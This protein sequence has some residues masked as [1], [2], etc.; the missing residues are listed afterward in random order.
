[1]HAG[2]ITV[3]WRT[4]EQVELC[5]FGPIEAR[6][7]L[8][9]IEFSRAKERAILAALA[10]FHGRTLSADRLVDAVWGDRLPARAEKAL[11]THVHRLR[12]VLGAVVVETRSNGYALA[13]NVVVDAEL[14]EDEAR[15]TGSA[16]RLRDALARWRGEPYGDLAAWP[17]AEME[18]ERLYELRDE[19]LE[20]CLELEI[21]AGPTGQCIA[22][23]EAMVADKPLREKRWLL[24]MTAL[25]RDGRV[26]DALRAYQRARKVFAE[27]LGIDPGRELRMLEER[28]LL[29]DVEPSASAD[30]SFDRVDRLDRAVPVGALPTGTV[31]FLITD[32]VGSTRLWEE[33]ADET[34][35]VALDRHDSVLRRAIERHGGS[36]VAWMGDGIAAVFASAGDA[37]DAALEAQQQ[38]M[39]DDRLR[40]RMALHT[41]EGRL[42]SP[43]EYVNRPINRCARLV[44]CAHGGQ[45]L[46]SDSTAAVAPSG[47][48]L[49]S[50]FRDLGAHRLR[51]LAEPM[52]VFQVEHAALPSEFPPLRS[53][54]AVPG[55]LPRQLTSFVGREREIADLARLARE[56]PL[57][58]LTGV[59]GV[60]KTR[61]A[62]QLAAQAI[63]D[64]RD[65]AWLCELAPVTDAN[66]L[67]ESLASSLGVRPQAGRSLLDLVLEFLALKRLVIVLDNCE[68]LLAPAARVV[69]A[70][71]QSCPEVAVVATSREAL[72]VQ[73]EL[74]VAIRPLSVPAIDAEADEL[75]QSDGTRLFCDRARD[76]NGAFMLT[77]GNA[78]A[79]AQLCRQLDG[80]P[81][82]IELAAARVRSLS[83]QDLAA[84]MDQ[85]FRLLTQSSRSAPT[86]HHTLRDTIDWSYD[87][88]N[89][90]EQ[91][92]LN[93]TSVFAGSFD[94]ASAEAVVGGEDIAGFDVVELLGRLVDKSLLEVDATDGITRYRL[95]ETIREYAREQLDVS[96][97]SVRVRGRHLTRYAD[98]AEEAGLLRGDA[99]LDRAGALARDTDNFRCALDWASGSGFV[100]D[101]LRLVVGLTTIGMATGW[102]VNDWAETAI[103]I[104][105]ASQHRLYPS[106]A[107]C[108]A[109]SAALR[110]DIDRAA[111]LVAIARAAQA[112]FGTDYPMVEMAAALLAM[113]QGNFDYA[114]HLAQRS[115]DR[116]R[117]AHDP[118]EIA[119]ALCLYATTLG[120]DAVRAALVA[121]EAVQVA[122]DA[123]A[124][125]TLVN[126]LLTLSGHVVHEQPERAR[127]LLDEAADLAQKLGDHQTL[128]VAIGFQAGIAIREQNWPVA[129]QAATDAAEQH[130][131]VGKSGAFAAILTLAYMALARME[132]PEP[133]AILAGATESDLPPLGLDQEWQAVANETDQLLLDALGA[134]RTEELKAQGAALTVADAVDYLKHQRDQAF[135]ARH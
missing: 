127:A 77:D 108:A 33:N 74:V 97:D 54:E 87:A 27:E 121:E 18:R 78:A 98:L 111:T 36:V 91:R 39:G 48:T 75:G 84:R 134:N 123:E 3:A 95:L 131:H 114:Q 125:F 110:V 52:R 59:G 45:I 21:D 99:Q 34:M 63:A 135:A 101:A 65:G 24:L 102:T 17:P 133:A 112:R 82:A 14:F 83:P 61:L 20:M 113:Y 71:V 103:A 47:L 79:V 66:V 116:A 11:Q 72:G 62:L 56:R 7:P 86:R 68:H 88:L 55:N 118:S 94:L 129:L 126:A 6:G 100:A 53:L 1:L 2:H 105:G 96:G 16:R 69:H 51:D 28:I 67:W 70:I 57:V 9:A 117:A 124:T 58:T 49:G 41:D 22:E 89:D 37:L 93:R 44:E 109:M 32:L 40:A 43:G 31:T 8:G 38:L 122:R 4:V 120:P 30:K 132:L 115:V 104:P 12:A 25:Q 15:T 29:A 85:R 46:V 23:L 107:G 50:S 42:R 76:A 73:G 90:R 92:V 64:F 13:A 130:L 81:L 119:G 128:A 10:L 5:V 80:I 60:G 19:A 26:A 35:S 106:A